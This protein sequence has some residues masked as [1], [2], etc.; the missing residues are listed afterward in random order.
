M[1]C[2]FV[3][4]L[5]REESK[6]CITLNLLNLRKSSKQAYVSAHAQTDF[7][8]VINLLDIVSSKHKLVPESCGKPRRH[9]GCRKGQ[10][11]NHSPRAG[12]SKYFVLHFPSFLVPSPH[13]RWKPPFTIGLI[14]LC[15]DRLSNNR[16]Q[17]TT[18]QRESLHCTISNYRIGSYVGGKLS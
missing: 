11:F 6:H 5:Y 17:S 3:W 1:F 13:H 9:L 8:D 2:N 10:G 7:D 14:S 12:S 15:L 18:T 4:M 16:E